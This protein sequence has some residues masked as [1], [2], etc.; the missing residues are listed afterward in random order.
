MKVLLDL[1]SID[2]HHCSDPFSS[3]HERR[4]YL[5]DYSRN[6]RV[7]VG[8]VLCIDYWRRRRLSFPI[9]LIGCDPPSLP[10]SFSLLSSFLLHFRHHYVVTE[11][12]FGEAIGG[13][14]TTDAR[15]FKFTL[16]ICCE[17]RNR[18]EGIDPVRVR[19]KRPMHEK[20][21]L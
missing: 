20:G 3:S 19:V 10:P 7:L 4:L 1:R 14:C 6:A 11:N 21:I 2:L 8:V 18:Y 16:Y 5:G 12:F 13:H 15:I 17:D 9:L